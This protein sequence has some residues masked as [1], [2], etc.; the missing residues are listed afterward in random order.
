MALTGCNTFDSTNNQQ[1]NM[2]ATTAPVYESLVQREIEKCNNFYKARK[3]NRTNAVGFHKCVI[4]AR[5]RDPLVYLD[6]DKVEDYKR[7][8][9][10]ESYAAK[11]IS[12]TQFN[13]KIAEYALRR[14]RANAALEMQRQSL[15]RADAAAQNQRQLLQYQ[16]ETAAAAQQNAEAA[17][18]AQALNTYLA[19]AAL[20]RQNTY[21]PIYIPVQPIQ[22]AAPTIRAPIRTNCNSFGSMTNCTTY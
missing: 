7:L 12:D 20:N 9:L 14:K 4:A 22:T 17:Q 5:E 1:Q 8:A 21:Q 2:T 11:Q 16:R 3:F 10:A 18:R 15:E 6:E 13:L 19:V